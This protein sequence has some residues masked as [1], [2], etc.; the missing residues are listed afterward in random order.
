MSS[1][2]A[3][4]HCIEVWGCRCGVCGWVTLKGLCLK[5]CVGVCVRTCVGVCVHMHVYMYICKCGRVLPPPPPPPAQMYIADP[6][7]IWTD[8]Q[9]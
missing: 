2:C 4:L 5:A 6:H 8:I 1:L 3:N 7:M 9:E